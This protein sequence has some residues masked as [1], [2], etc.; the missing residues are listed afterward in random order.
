MRGIIVTKSVFEVLVCTFGLFACVVVW[1]FGDV[2]AFVMCGVIRR[3]LRFIY[4]TTR[5]S[6]IEVLFFCL[7]SR[8]TTVVGTI[9]KRWVCL[10]R[11]VCYIFL[12]V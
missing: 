7:C 2:G 10:G 11:G 6:A 1:C 5:G 8:D 3:G 9:G 12:R 4:R